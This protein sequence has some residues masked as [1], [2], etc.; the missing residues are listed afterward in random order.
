M[1]PKLGSSPNSGEYVYQI[2]SVA[3]VRLPDSEY[4]LEIYAVVIDDQPDWKIIMINI[5]KS[6]FLCARSHIKCTSWVISF[7]P[8]GTELAG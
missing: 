6:L 3:S 4:P 2:A 7:N 8:D 1:V 5:S